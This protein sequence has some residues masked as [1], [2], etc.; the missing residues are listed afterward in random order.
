VLKS[1]QFTRNN[2]TN[3]RLYEIFRQNLS[4]IVLDWV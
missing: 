1:T 2:Y 4:R 3:M